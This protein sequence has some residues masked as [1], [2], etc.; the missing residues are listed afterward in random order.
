MYMYIWNMHQYQLQC[1][2]PHLVRS[3]WDFVRHF[4]KWV[5]LEHCLTSNPC[6]F[7]HGTILQD[8]REATESGFVASWAWK[9]IP[10]WIPPSI[11]VFFGVV[12][13]GYHWI[14]I[15][16]E[17]CIIHIQPGTFWDLS[18]ASLSNFGVGSVSGLLDTVECLVTCKAIYSSP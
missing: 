5:E 10:S 11:Y 18:F 12:H 3:V 8:Q 9:S 17:S 6:C 16:N 2:C 13:S 1:I 15:Y 4:K 7:I 14:K